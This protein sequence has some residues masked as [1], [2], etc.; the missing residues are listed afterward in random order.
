[1]PFSTV[2]I[3]FK[4]RYLQDVKFRSNG[5]EL[6]LLPEQ[7]GIYTQLRCYRSSNMKMILPPLRERRAVDR[8]L[9]AFFQQYRATDFRRAI[10][11]LCRFYHLRNPKVEWFEYLDW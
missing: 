9:S 8:L 6:F 10:G 1:M 3:T 4:N 2:Q 7:Y 5:L 11:S